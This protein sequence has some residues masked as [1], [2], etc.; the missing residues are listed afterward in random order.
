MFVLIKSFDH[1][2]GPTAASPVYVE[3]PKISDFNGFPDCQRVL[4]V[5]TQI[6]DSAVR[7]G[8]SQPKLNGT[9]GT[10]FL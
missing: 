8:M 5:D 4:K 2:D 7:L 3:R 10:R 6:S 9:Q 1:I